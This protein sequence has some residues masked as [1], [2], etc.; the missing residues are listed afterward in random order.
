MVAIVGSI[1]F[2]ILISYY[3]F[4]THKLTLVLFMDVDCVPCT[5]IHQFQVYTIYRRFKVN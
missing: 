2:F 3:M 1:S 5:A 4:F